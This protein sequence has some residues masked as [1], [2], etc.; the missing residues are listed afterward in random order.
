[1]IKNQYKEEALEKIADAS[2]TVEV[3]LDVLHNGTIN[4]TELVKRLAAIKSD[5]ENA[6]K[7]LD[8]V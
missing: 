7:Y 5:L 2:R 1:M 3:L 4:T 8:F 6:K